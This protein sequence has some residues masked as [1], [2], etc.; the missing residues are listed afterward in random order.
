MV[1]YKIYIRPSAVKELKKIPKKVLQK[2]VSR[3]K[4]LSTNPRP[5][6]CEKLSDEERYRIRQGNY[7]IVYSIEDA[8]LIVI[9]VKVSHRS[10]V[11]KK[12]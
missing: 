10:N 5:F 8:A 6:G 7:R 12:R 9:V 4:G 2:I 3:I 1:K 11:Y